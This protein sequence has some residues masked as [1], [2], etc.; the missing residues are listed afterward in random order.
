ML[1]VHDHASVVWDSGKR[2]RCKG[3]HLLRR[4]RMKEWEVGEE[5]KII[6][7]PTTGSGFGLGEMKVA[8]PSYRA[9]NFIAKHLVYCCTFSSI[10]FEEVRVVN[11]FFWFP[12][13]HTIAS[14]GAKFVEKALDTETS[15]AEQ[16]KTKG[17]SG[18]M[19][20]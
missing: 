10:N 16:T 9:F 11:K 4:K 6:S 18:H 8:S 19:V 14:V 13:H 7:R 17:E 15:E 3:W 2:F 1:Q 20:R 5:K 12:L